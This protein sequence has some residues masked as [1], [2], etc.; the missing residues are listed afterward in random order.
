VRYRRKKFTFAISSRDEFL[1]RSPG[2]TS[3][4]AYYWFV[5]IRNIGHR[6]LPE[7]WVGTYPVRSVQPRGKTLNWY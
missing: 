3:T 2:S 4:P 6:T 5:I 1:Y 7:I